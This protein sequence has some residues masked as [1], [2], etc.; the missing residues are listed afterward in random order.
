MLQ[1][2]VHAKACT[3]FFGKAVAVFN[4]GGVTCTESKV[5][6]CIFVKQ[7]VEK[8][9]SAFG[10]GGIFTYQGNFSQR[11]H[12]LVGG[13]QIFQSVVSHFR[14][15]VG[16]FAVGKGDFELI[17]NVA[18][19]NKRK[20]VHHGTVNFFVVR[21]RE[22]LFR[23]HVCSESNSVLTFFF[24]GNPLM[25]RCKTD[26]YV[27][28]ATVFHVYV[29]EIVLVEKFRTFVKFGNVRLPCRNGV[30]CVKTHDVSYCVPHFVHGLLLGQVG[31]NLFRPCGGR[32][33]HYRPTQVVAH[34]G[35]TK[36]LTCFGKGKL[37]GGEFICVASLVD[38]GVS[39]RNGN[40]TALVVYEILHLVNLVLRNVA[41]SFFGGVQHVESS[42]I[43]VAPLHDDFVSTKLIGFFRNQVG[44]FA[45]FN[46]AT[47]H[48]FLPLLHICADGNRQFG[49]FFHLC[50]CKHCSLLLRYCRIT[51]KLYAIFPR[52]S[53]KC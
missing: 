5:A 53:I 1:T 52:K 31:E 45:A 29:L 37:I 11:Q 40:K 22:N 21:R 10:N 32:H 7:G 13:Q 25:S 34:C 9:N 28:S 44:K 30:G 42:Q 48:N 2:A 18:V 43:F 35:V 41:Q 24:G 8:Q 47:N 23:R 16:N 36:R 6:T 39:C 51:G 49:K 12:A 19:V 46:V 3:L 14:R 38:V 4:G 27:R 20:G 26:F 15:I 33:G 50:V 17:N